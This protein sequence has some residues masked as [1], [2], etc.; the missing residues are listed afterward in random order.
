M[1]TW[2]ARAY[3]QYGAYLLLFLVAWRR[4]GAPERILTGIMLG[5]IVVDR[6]YHL[7]RGT[8]LLV[9]HGVDVVHLAIDTSSL[10]GIGY[11][12]LQANRF[13]PLWIGGAQIIAFSSHFYRLGIVEIDKTAYQV[14]SIIPSYVQLL[15]MALG[16]AFHMRRQ[17]RRGSYPSWRKSSVPS[18]AMAARSLPAV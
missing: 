15:A 14:M 11:V 18:S 7:G 3:L 1:L 9:Y 17:K 10:L 4:G 2:G 6:I 12:A 13:Y 16:L 8:D 5:M